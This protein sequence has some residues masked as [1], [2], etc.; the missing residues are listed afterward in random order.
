[1]R[2]T[3]KPEPSKEKIAKLAFDLQVDATI[4]KILLQRNIETFEDA[5]KYFMMW[6]ELL[7]FL[8]FLPI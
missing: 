1:M 6:M 4:A 8:W 5:K 3:L 7:L 2:W